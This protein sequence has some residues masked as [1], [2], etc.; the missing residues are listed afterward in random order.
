MLAE[1]AEI[2]Q[3]GRGRDR[4]AR[5]EAERDRPD[6]LRALVEEYLERARLWPELH[7]QAESVRYAFAVGRQ[8]RPAG[9]LPRDRRGGRRRARARPARGGRARARAQLLARPRRPARARR[10]RGAARQAER[11]GRVR[12]GGRRCSPATRCSRRRSGSRCRTRRREVARELAEATLGMIGGQ[13][14][15]TT[16]AAPTSATLHRLKTG[17]LFSASV[18]AG[19]LGGRRAASASRPR[20]ARSATSSG[21][22]SRSS[23]TS[24]TRRLRRRRSAPTARGALADEA[25]ERA[26]RRARRGRRGHDASSAGIVATSPSARRER[27]PG[28]SRPR[29]E[30]Q[31]GVTRPARLMRRRSRARTRLARA[32]DGR[33]R[34]RR[35]AT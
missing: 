14:L 4:A 7:G 28:R 21:C 33:S 23:T 13:Y 27:T 35:S 31:D 30:C 2:A 6:E 10:R 18:G 11:L 1:L 16:G 17:R 15:D 26:R 5:R 22:S 19:A 32:S 29:P 9:D 25:A 24:S 3:A 20:G 8:A 12:R 34:Q